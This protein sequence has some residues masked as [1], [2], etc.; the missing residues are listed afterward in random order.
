MRFT[1]PRGT[2]RAST[3]QDRFLSP[4]IHNRLVERGFGV[5]YNPDFEEKYL[6][7]SGWTSAGE[8][9]LHPLGQGMDSITRSPCP[10]AYIGRL[11][12]VVQHSRVAAEYLMSR[13][14]TVIGLFDERGPASPC[15]RAYEATRNPLRRAKRVAW[16]KAVVQQL[17]DE[18]AGYCAPSPCAVLTA[19][20]R[21]AVESVLSAHPR[22]TS[23]G[24]G[25]Y[26][27]H[28]GNP[29][30]E[31]T[32]AAAEFERLRSEMLGD[33]QILQFIAADAFLCSAGAPIKTLN[34][35]RSSYGLKHDVEGWLERHGV[36]M[37]YVS[38]GMFIAAA[39]ARGFRGEPGEPSSP[40]LVF[41]IG[42]TGLAAAL[43]ADMPREVRSRLALPVGLVLA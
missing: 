9:W 4:V 12:V 8:L 42:Q 10:M 21:A 24:L 5:S 26:G 32:P 28:R 43:A 33:Q 34:R 31:H 15:Y 30:E 6:S 1:D 18:D 38:N 7:E 16:D 20:P 36:D 19:N 3:L 25:I 17:D 27:E 22:L 14:W 29:H 11:A 39:L 2:N 35:K 37:T 40:N 23:R 13:G 41:N